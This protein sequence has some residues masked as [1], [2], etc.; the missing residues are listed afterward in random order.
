[1]TKTEASKFVIVLGSTSKEDGIYEILKLIAF[2]FETGYESCLPKE[3]ELCSD[4][5]CLRKLETTKSDGVYL[6]TPLVTVSNYLS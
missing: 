1:V 5:G 3:L 2:S 4:E 6:E